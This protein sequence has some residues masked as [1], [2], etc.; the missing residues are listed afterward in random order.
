MFTLLLFTCICILSSH[1]A[2]AKDFQLTRHSA[3]ENSNL[4]AFDQHHFLQPV[5]FSNHGLRCF[6]R[7]A[8]NRPEYGTDFLPNNFFHFVQFLKRDTPQARSYYQSVLRMFGNKLKQSMYINPYA[9]CQMLD[10]IT[11]CLQKA[12]SDERPP[13][14]KQLQTKI[15]STMYNAMLDKFDYLK[16][17]PDAYFH[18]LSEDII[19]LVNTTQELSG[20]ASIEEL[21]K[22]FMV[23][24]ET[25][26][27][28]LIW[29]PN[30]Y[31]HAWRNVK[32]IAD[33]LA[34]LYE[35]DI[36]S[37]QDDL[38]DLFITLLERF[39]LFLDLSYAE[40]PVEFYQ[41]V[42]QDIQAKNLLLLELEQE[43]FIETKAQR[44][45]RAITMTEAKTRAYHSGILV[46]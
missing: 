46:S 10:E 8:Y 18:D 32:V 38:N 1:N 3:T 9:Y 27:N 11:P 17:D 39:C 14:F 22:S 21:R 30:E 25:T 33:Q 26:V 44:L 37:D 13:I 20:D 36:L 19:S 6:I 4:I 24:F 43:Q 28:K 34:R 15:S 2:N 16:I 35:K 23:F 42:R 41:A 12:C 5:K 45:E 40:I 7:H 29:S 31:E